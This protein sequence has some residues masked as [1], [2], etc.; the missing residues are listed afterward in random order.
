MPILGCLPGYPRR[1]FTGQIFL[2]PSQTRLRGLLHRQDLIPTTGLFSPRYVSTPDRFYASRSGPAGLAASQRSALRLGESMFTQF[3]LLHTGS[4]TG[5]GPC[6]S[7]RSSAGWSR[8]NITPSSGRSR[9]DPPRCV[10][11]LLGHQILP[12]LVTTG[13][14]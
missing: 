7:S 11:P 12:S 4:W 6:S 8:G 1:P 13:S 5:P 10:L 9:I 14:T 2:S 3:T